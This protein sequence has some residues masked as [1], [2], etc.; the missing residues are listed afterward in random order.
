MQKVI[1]WEP[2]LS[3]GFVGVYLICAGERG[4]DDMRVLSKGKSEC[5]GPTGAQHKE[6]T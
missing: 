4:L 2:V 6:L 5:E 1:A 3:G